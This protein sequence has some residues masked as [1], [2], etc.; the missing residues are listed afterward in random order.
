MGM[1]EEEE[2]EKGEK[3]ERG[4]CGWRWRWRWRDRERKR[5]HGAWR[6]HGSPGGRII[7]GLFRICFDSAVG[8][9]CDLGKDTKKEQTNKQT[10][11]A[12]CDEPRA[13]HRPLPYLP[14]R[15]F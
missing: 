10:E 2:I 14:I 6:C 15:K 3:E 5:E 12:R 13:T 9:M 11:R 1:E 8:Q 7:F 4:K